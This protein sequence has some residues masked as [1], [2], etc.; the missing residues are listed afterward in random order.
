M[1]FL[2]LVLSTEVSVC[3]S[4][5]YYYYTHNQL[6]YA[7][8]YGWISNC[9]VYGTQPSHLLGGIYKKSTK[10]VKKVTKVPLNIPDS[11]VDDSDNWVSVN[12]I[13]YNKH[14]KR[15]FYYMRA[16]CAAQLPLQPTSDAAS[17]MTAC[18]DSYQ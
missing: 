12:E 9:C 4:W 17:K 2:S 3:W 11:R 10:K 13:T 8:Y 16:N 18:L 14:G 7:D 6:A 5:A 1:L 15:V